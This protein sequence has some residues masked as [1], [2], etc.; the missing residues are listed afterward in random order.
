M[1]FVSLEWKLQRNLFQYLHPTIFVG[2]VF[3][4]YVQLECGE[5]QI[6]DEKTGNMNYFL[7]ALPTAKVQIQKA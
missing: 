3:E 6:I 2:D 1:R 7:S 4:N 5:T